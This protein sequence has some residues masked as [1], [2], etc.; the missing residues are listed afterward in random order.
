MRLS[1]FEIKEKADLVDIIERADVC[2]IAFAVEETPYIVALNFGYE[3]DDTLRLYA[4]GAGEGRM[5]DCMK[6]NPFVCFQMDIDHGLFRGKGACEWGMTY[7]SIVGYGTLATIE[8][9]DE[10]KKALDLIMTHYGSKGSNAYDDKAL[11]AT[12][13]FR[14]EASEVAGKKRVK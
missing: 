8:D 1:E 14:I 13:I 10:R 4:H 12:S 7:K 6:K 2:R 3:W 5:I 11:R 9:A